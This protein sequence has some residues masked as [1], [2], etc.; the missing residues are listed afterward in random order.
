MLS[1][2]LHYRRVNNF[3]TDIKRTTFSSSSSFVKKLPFQTSNAVQLSVGLTQLSR[4]KV[5]T[6]CKKPFQHAFTYFIRFLMRDYTVNF[7]GFHS[8]ERVGLGERTKNP[9]LPK[10]RAPMTKEG[11]VRR[12]SVLIGPCWGCDGGVCRLTQILIHGGC[13]FPRMKRRSGIL[14]SHAA[15]ENLL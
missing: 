15:L 5:K 8:S 2:F 7:C 9:A 1:F 6:N 4:D 12:W 10:Q 13:G 11:R 3:T 14:C